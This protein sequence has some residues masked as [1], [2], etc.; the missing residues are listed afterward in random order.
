MDLTVYINDWSKTIAHPCTY[1]LPETNSRQCSD[2]EK[3]Q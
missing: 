2:R 3:Y 1:S